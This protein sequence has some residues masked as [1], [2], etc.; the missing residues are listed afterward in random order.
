MQQLLSDPSVTCGEFLFVSTRLLPSSRGETQG[1]SRVRRPA[2]VANDVAL[3][4]RPGSGVASVGRKRAQAGRERALRRDSQQ[5]APPARARGLSRHAIDARGRTGC[6]PAS[7]G[8]S[9]TPREVASR[10]PAPTW[11]GRPS[12][13]YLPKS[14]QRLR[15]CCCL[16]LGRAVALPL[17][18]CR[19]ATS[20]GFRLQDDGTRCAGA[21]GPLG[22]LA[23][24]LACS[25][26]ARARSSAPSPGFVARLA[27]G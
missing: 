15:P 2:G 21:V 9:G 13:R 18:R 4:R 16:K 23:P 10:P 24:P 22:E 27:R 14:I 26:A 3:R 7:H 25:S 6:L 19:L 11:T 12:R 1:P 17:P 5:L 20:S 8:T